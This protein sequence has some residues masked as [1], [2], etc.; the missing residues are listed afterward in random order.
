MLE[1]FV[2]F[3]LD[4]VV[5]LGRDLQIYLFLNKVL[6]CQIDLL[7]NLFFD[8]AH[9]ILLH[10]V[11]NFRFYH[12]FYVGEN[13]GVN[14]GFNFVVNSILNLTIDYG[15]ESLNQVPLNW[16]RNLNSNQI[17]ELIMKINPDDVTFGFY[18][19]GKLILDTD[20]VIFKFFSNFIIC[21]VI[22]LNLH[23]FAHVIFQGLVPQIYWIIN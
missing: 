13:L 12:I 6:S 23:D 1:Y 4:L 17:L 15:L 2:D 10:M 3:L 7:V 20:F 18:H 9:H 19:F 21:L 14:D 22:N 8:H 16:C 5:N 11:A